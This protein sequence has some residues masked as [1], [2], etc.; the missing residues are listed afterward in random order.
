MHGVQSM[1]LFP[2]KYIQTNVTLARLTNTQIYVT[3]NLHGVGYREKSVVWIKF[4]SRPIIRLYCVVLF[5]YR[6]GELNIKSWVSDATT[7]KYTRDWMPRTLWGSFFLFFFFLRQKTNKYPTNRPWT[8]CP[9]L[10]LRWSTKP[11]NYLRVDRPI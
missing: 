4:K 6:S 11:N 2:R 10:F 5:G 1:K 3:Q 8:V 7:P 9:S